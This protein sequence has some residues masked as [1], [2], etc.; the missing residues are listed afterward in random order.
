[1]TASLPSSI[2]GEQCWS[3]FHERRQQSPGWMAG[4]RRASDRQSDRSDADLAPC[5]SGRQ[6]P[7][8]L[9][10]P[11][12]LPCGHTA[13]NL[14][15]SDPCRAAAAFASRGGVAQL[16]DS[17]WMHHRGDALQSACRRSSPAKERPESGNDDQRK[18]DQSECPVFSG[19]GVSVRSRLLPVPP[20]LTWRAFE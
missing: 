10:D 7:S 1:M 9:A 17:T 12:Q 3:T 19:K 18:R 8:A 16:P 15:R 2:V 5:R 6:R 11:R 4:C 14:C 13:H 20:R